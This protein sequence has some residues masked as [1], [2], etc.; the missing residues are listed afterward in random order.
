MVRFVKA[1]TLGLVLFMFGI[2]S[3]LADAPLVWKGT[4]GQ[5]LTRDGWELKSGEKYLHLTANPSV[6]AG[7]AAPVGSLGV[8]DNAGVGVL[9]LKTGASNTAWTDILSSITGVS[10][11]REIQTQGPLTG[12][13]DLSADRTIAIPEADAVTDGYMPATRVQELEAATAAN[14]AQGTAITAAQGDATQALSDAADAATLAADAQ[15]DADQGIAD[16][17]AA[18]ADADQALAD[19]ADA[20]S[21][22]DALEPR[23]AAEEAATVAQGTYN[24]ANDT[25][26][27]EQDDR[28]TD[29]EAAPP[30]ETIVAGDTASV[31]MTRTGDTLTSDVKLSA[32]AA[33]LGKTKAELSVESDGLLVQLPH[34]GTGTF[35]LIDGTRVDN[36][37]SGKQAGPLTGDVTTPSASNP[38][39]TISAGAVD[40]NKLA[41][42]AVDLAGTKVT[43][44]LPVNKL[45]SGTSASA[46]TFWRG[47][48]TWA[49]PP[50]A[51][52]APSAISKDITQTAHGLGVGNVVRLSGTNYIR[53]QADN[54]TNAEGVVGIV[55][56]VGGANTFTLTMKGYVTG[57]SGLTAGAAYYLHPGLAGGLITPIPVGGG[58]VQKQIF[59]AD[60]TTSG[61]FDAT[62]T[63]A[64]QPITLSGGTYNVTTGKHILGA[65]NVTGA[66]FYT[67]GLTSFGNPAAAGGTPSYSPSYGATAPGANQM[68]I[69]G[70]NVPGPGRVT[71]TYRGSLIGSE[72]ANTPSWFRAYD[73]TKASNEESQVKQTYQTYSVQSPEASFTFDYTSAQTNLTYNL[74]CKTVSSGCGFSYQASD[75]N[76]ITVEWAPATSANTVATVINGD[77]LAGTDWQEY[78]LTIGGATTAPTKGTVS[79]DRARWRRVGDSMEIRYDYRQTTAGG[80]GSGT[81]LFPLPYG[82]RIDTSKQLVSSS[83]YHYVGSGVASNVADGESATSRPIN[84][85]AYNDSSL[86][87]NSAWTEVLE[88]IGA[89]S[90]SISNANLLYSFTARVPIAGWSSNVTMAKSSAFYISSKLTTRVS[91]RAPEKEGEYRALG[92]NGGAR[93]FTDYNPG[94]LP[95]PANGIPLYKGNAYS[96]ADTSGAPTRWDIFVGRNKIVN[97]EAFMSTG[98]TGGLNLASKPSIS[99][100]YDVGFEYAY[101]SGSGIFT[102]SRP[103]QGGTAAHYIGTDVT[104][105]DSTTQTNG[106][107]DLLV[108]EKTQVVGV[109]R[110]DI[111]AV[112]AAGAA[113]Y[114]TAAYAPNTSCDWQTPASNQNPQD[115]TSNASCP[116]ATTT[117]F[118]APDTAGTPSFKMKQTAGDVFGFFLSGQLSATGTGCSFRVSN[119]TDV[120][121]LAGLVG[122]STTGVGSAS[123]FATAST[124]N[125]AATWKIQATGQNGSENCYIGNSRSTRTL[126]LTV[127]RY[128]KEESQPGTILR[129]DPKTNLAG[130]LASGSRVTGRDPNVLGEYRYMGRASSGAG[131][132]DLAPPP[133]SITADKGIPLWKGGSWATADTSPTRIDIYVGT[134]N[135]FYTV[136]AYGSSSGARTNSIDITPDYSNTYSTGFMRSYSAST[137]VLTFTRLSNGSDTAHFVGRDSQTGD[138]NG[139]AYAFLDVTLISNPYAAGLT[140]VE[141]EILLGGHMG[142]SSTNTAI[143]YYS[144]V[145]RQKGISMVLTSNNST[146][147]TAVTVQKDGLYLCQASM[148]INNAGNWAGCVVDGSAYLSSSGQLWPFDNV[149]WRAISENATGGYITQ[150]AGFRYLRAG[151]VIRPMQQTGTGSG[152]GSVNS[153]FYVA[154]VP[155]PFE[156]AGSANGGKLR[157]IMFAFGG[158]T[159]GVNECNS[160]PCTIYRQYDDEGNTTRI[161]SVNRTSAGRY[162]VNVA[163]G[164]CLSPMVITYNGKHSSNAGNGYFPQAGDA[165][166]TTT[167]AYLRFGDSSASNDTSVQGVITCLR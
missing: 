91:G 38:A 6:G 149:I 53:A 55:S 166:N 90:Y 102:I 162:T 24:T 138:V 3:A 85:F 71:V 159:E 164:A 19:A 84:V 28:L 136:T 120:S 161:T 32:A 46:T 157:Q 124:T 130:I 11:T 105:G 89:T 17:A 50:S 18:Q 75:K 1:W 47:D 8:W 67:S 4:V 148:D 156:V 62:Q 42:G 131:W 116:A 118:L 147:G 27:V 145:V 115:F 12:G 127:V 139:S 153:M 63:L 152:A 128:P 111:P 96:S 13:G 132:S 49:V 163:A 44:N 108:S 103:T 15:A 141:E 126:T 48:G 122:N 81:Y 78:P 80:A 2:A 60:S 110:G 112:V 160:N 5:F 64:N 137:G 151:Q 22:V 40:G 61:Y 129:K 16:A 93:T 33:D 45:N 82:Y 9:F 114:G 107:F 150:G 57:L 101:D 142:P 155:S 167:A 95:G 70:I 154:K 144:T 73:G 125:S 134:D 66:Y 98:K 72:N 30:G 52:G 69:S 43:G 104:T 77:G 83:R 58:A 88:A 23:V 79:V 36:L 100:S 54:A 92:R 99:G 87:L 34:A 31:D 35:G 59:Y 21:D 68:A 7:L 140:N 146:L 133:V 165:T 117:G 158:A 113:V 51:G 143:P 74:Q 25:K 97:L 29:L 94:I 65:V 14:T 37:E 123:L 56:A 106:Y 10:A 20:Q 26:N 41:V 39:T 119:G 121:P 135:P 76:S 109:E 86:A